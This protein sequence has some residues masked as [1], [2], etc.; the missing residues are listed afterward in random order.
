[1]ATINVNVYESDP[2]CNPVAFENLRKSYSDLG[3]K[4]DELIK[5]MGHEYAPFPDEGTDGFL[6]HFIITME[7][8]IADSNGEIVSLTMPVATQT[9]TRSKPFIYTGKGNH[10]ID[11]NLPEGCSLPNRIK[12]SDFLHTPSEFFEEGKETVWMQIINLDARMEESPIGPIRIIL[13]ETLKREYSDLFQPS[14]GVAQALGK[15]GGFPAKLF[16]NPY[17]IIETKFG[18]MRAIHGTLSYGRVTSFPPV[19]TAISICEMIPL[20]P[21][22]Q[23]RQVNALRAISPENIKPFAR[24]IALAH[25]IDTPMQLSGDEAFK[26]IERSIGK[27]FL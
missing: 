22:E 2:D 14:L 13:G 17:A 23:V 3:E 20:E 12:E 11:F 10:E 18:A 8:L 1:M 25:P 9:V 19:G 6:S 16:F 27:G 4:Y 15:K 21:V 26:L 7:L 24:I 5:F